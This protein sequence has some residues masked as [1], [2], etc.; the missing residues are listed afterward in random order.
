MNATI[1]LIPG[2]RNGIGPELL[3]KV[4][5][6]S[7]K[8]HGVRPVVV[9]DPR[10]FADGCRVA[11]VADDLPRVGT[12]AAGQTDAEGAVL[13][14]YVAESGIET[15]PGRVAAAAGRESLSILAH[16]VALAGEGRVD[17][18][19]YAPL[20][21]QA[22]HQAGLAFDDEMDF[23]ADAM[24]F[25]GRHGAINVVD[26]LWTTRVTSHVSIGAVASLITRERVVSAIRFI[27]DALVAA[28]RAGPR[29]GVAALN[30]HGGDGGRFGREEIDAIAPAVDEA[31]R[32]GIDAD[33]P[34]PSDTVF[35]KARDGRFDGVV[36]M[37]H[38]QSQIAMKLLGFRRG[39]AVLGGLPIPVTT[40]AHGTGYD[41]VGR[42]EADPG[43]LEQALA[44]C[45]RMI[46]RRRD[47]GGDG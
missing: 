35:V 20:N 32:A 6:G 40:C 29:I 42:G 23:I 9:G 34:H 3:A 8:W 28:G 31:R 15:T 1:A 41:I 24:G 27:H 21:K 47:S 30:P 5:A 7:G 19:V 25:A 13:L 44:V 39:V 14:E 2:D 26:D 12:L 38:D 22:M 37:Y 46:G 16:A 17:G 33:G 10:V 11:G 18:I 43:A 4:L 45:R 36:T